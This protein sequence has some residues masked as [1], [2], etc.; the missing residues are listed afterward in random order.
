MLTEKYFIENVVGI[1]A[2]DDHHLFFIWEQSN[3][4]CST[5]SENELIWSTEINEKQP[6][7]ADLPAVKLLGENRLIV[8]G[9]NSFSIINKKD[10]NTLFHKS[11]G[12]LDANIT[13]Q[14]NLVYGLYFDDGEN[15]NVLKLNT[16]SFEM[17]VIPVANQELFNFMGVNGAQYLQWEGTQITGA[18]YQTN[19]TNWVN[20]V[21]EIG[22]FE[23]LKDE[24]MEGQ[25]VGRPLAYG[26]LCIFNILG[27]HLVAIH[28]ISGKIA[29]KLKIEDVNCADNL[30]IQEDR[31][32][33]TGY[34]NYYEIDPSTGELVKSVAT[35]ALYKKHNISMLSTHFLY[36][37]AIV[38]LHGRS[39]SQLTIINRTTF[40]IQQTIDLE[41]KVWADFTCSN[42]NT[43]VTRDL[44]G[45]LTVISLDQ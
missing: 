45:V 5:I 28:S 37:E 7:G 38:I 35:S 33:I 19:Q 17:T 41:G 2:C 32:H 4:V 22:K 16:E 1:P 24:W 31:L 18:S 26:E 25:V 14:G 3:L 29:W 6:I 12:Q 40:E 39:D 42:D 15:F 8:L 23:Q 20:Y 44:D 34:L 21:S 9:E 27:H 11:G 13:V 36:K 10:G 43:I 30:S